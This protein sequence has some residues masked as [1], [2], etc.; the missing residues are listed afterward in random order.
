[1]TVPCPTT[2]DHIPPRACGTDSQQA[3]R[4]HRPQRVTCVRHASADK[5]K[6]HMRPLLCLDVFKE[7]I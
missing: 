1:M 4:S 7:R 5:P 2:A 3:I 6:M